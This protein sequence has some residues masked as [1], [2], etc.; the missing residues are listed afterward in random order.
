MTEGGTR[1]GQPPRATVAGLPG[2]GGPERGAAAGP[3]KEPG[4]TGEQEPS[5]LEERYRRWLRLLP[6]SYRAVW[7]DEM[8]AT[9]AD[10]MA[11]DDPDDAE[12]MADYGRP[13]WSE[14]GSVLAL[15]VRLR[16]GG[17][18]GPARYVAWGAAVRQVAL[19]G[20]LVQ[21]ALAIDGVIMRLWEAGVLPGLPR[22]AL[23][24]R[25]PLPTNRLWLVWQFSDLLWVAAFLAL[26]VGNRRAARLL[27]PLAI[28][29]SAVAAVLLAANRIRAGDWPLPGWQCFML[30]TFVLLAGTLAA[31]HR[32]A[33]PV[34]PRPWLVALSIG[35][36]LGAVLLLTPLALGYLLPIDAATMWCLALV[37]AGAAHLAGPRLRRG[38]PVPGR[39]QALALLAVPVLVLRI[40]L[41]QVIRSQIDP[42]PPVG[43]TVAGVVEIVAVLAVGVP[44]WARAVRMLRNLP[45]ASADPAATWSAPAP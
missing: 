43:W 42:L 17:S 11:T 26:V 32:D 12:F 23:E 22:P 33:P 21:A 20:L 24:W 44:L 40:V 9:F 36:A 41:L 7:A 45:P 25:F 3:A 31:F 8:V 37:A 15:A 13:S 1:D 18:G 2:G 38:E 39:T 27:T 30:L 4:P 34:A 19:L 29:P 16:L 35:A 28:V 10:S 5:Q 6:A 14:I